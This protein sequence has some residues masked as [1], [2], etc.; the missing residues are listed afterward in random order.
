MGIFFRIWSK[1][2][3]IVYFVKTACH[4]G[5]IE[6][7]ILSPKIQKILQFGSGNC[8]YKMCVKPNRM[9]VQSSS[10]SLIILSQN[11]SLRHFMGNNCVIILE[12]LTL[13]L[14]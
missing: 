13:Q 7:A 4:G 3:L 1:V 6:I 2:A 11:L 14:L 9:S 10:E 8:S 5:A 12:A